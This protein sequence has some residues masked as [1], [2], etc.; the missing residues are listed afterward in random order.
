VANGWFNEEV[1]T[2]WNFE[3]APWRG[4]PR[5][6][7]QPEVYG[8]DGS[9]A[10][11]TSDE[12]TVAG[13]GPVVSAGIRTGVSVD[14]AREISMV[15]P[16][17]PCEGPGGQLTAQCYPPARPTEVLRPEVITAPGETR[18]VY[19]FAQN[20]SGG[21]A[22][23]LSGEFA[24]GADRGIRV[25]Y[26]ERLDDNGNLDTSLASLTHG[27]FQTDEIL[28]SEEGAATANSEFRTRF[29]YHGFRYAQIDASDPTTFEHL[30]SVQAVRIAMDFE[31]IGELTCSDRRLDRLVRCAERSYLSN[32]H[33]IPTDCPHREKNGWTADA[34]L[35]APFGL[36]TYRAEAAYRKWMDDFADE[37]RADGALPGII[38]TSGWGTIGGMGRHG[39]LPTS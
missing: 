26:G 2:A 13:L 17:T 15:G 16:A 27:R 23:G 1:G 4:E 39:T 31:R 19:D 21:I 30:Q 20:L 25:T 9:R 11:V 28:S 6:L 38:P 33:S 8:A 29:C 24:R 22:L 34:H 14:L 37:Q 18:R 32:F 10:W 35:A 7:Y 36:Y 5:L 3:H 12:N